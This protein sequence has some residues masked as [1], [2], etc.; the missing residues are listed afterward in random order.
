VKNGSLMAADFK[1]G[2]LPAGPLLLQAFGSGSSSGFVPDADEGTMK[3]T[4]SE[5]AGDQARRQNE[6]VADE[7]GRRTLGR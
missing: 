6:P 4:W 5:L 1:A 7:T 3:Q 2:Q